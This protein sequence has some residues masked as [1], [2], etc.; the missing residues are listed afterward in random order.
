[1]GDRAQRV[2]KQLQRELS[3][4]ISLE[5][6]DPRL[7]GVS[8]TRIELTSDLRFARVYVSRLGVEELEP[9]TVSTLQRAAGRIR[10][11]LGPRADLKYM[12]DL[13]F[14]WDESISASLQM[15]KTLE[16][17]D[18]ARSE[19]SMMSDEPSHDLPTG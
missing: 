19:Q 3:E 18:I 16:R 1:M 15:E 9:H 17:L 2:A 12:P 5:L 14:Y 4:I 7:E 8:V 13:R 11:L 6:R 10:H